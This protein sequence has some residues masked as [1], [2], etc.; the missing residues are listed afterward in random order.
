MGFI[1]IWEQ[2]D[3]CNPMGRTLM[4]IV[5][6][7]FQLERENIAEHIRDNMYEPAKTGHWLGGNIP[8]GYAFA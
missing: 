8:T 4:Y 3:T 1:S 6:V 5:S 7:F 2:F